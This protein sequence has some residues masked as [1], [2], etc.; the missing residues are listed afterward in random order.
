MMNRKRALF[1]VLLGLLLVASA[2]ASPVAPGD[3]PEVQTTEVSE[4]RPTETAEVR[5][6]E[7]A[8]LQPTDT[9]DVQPTATPDVQP[10]EAS[11][12]RPA[13][14]PDV[15]AT[16]AAATE[17]AAVRPIEE[18]LVSGP[19]FTDIGPTI[20]TVLAE[21]SIPMAC[22]AVYG[23]TQEYGQIATDTDM[24]GGGH[25]DHHPLLTGLEPDTVYYVRLQGVGPDGTLYQSEEYTFR[26]TEAETSETGL[27]LAL[28]ENGARLV[29]SSSNYGGGA[30][31]SSFGA[32]NATDGNVATQWSSDGDGDEAW[33]EIELAEQT[34]VT[35][36]GFW[37]RT[38]GSSAQIERF[39]VTTDKGETHGPFE[40]AD[41]AGTHY[42]DTDFVARRL[43]FDVLSSSGGNTGAVEIEVY[44]QQP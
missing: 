31:D 13:E 30:D 36:L 19:E 29:G 26:T 24:A 2:C 21:T 38:M 18:I 7:T 9:P 28:P 27:N 35:R 1:A 40:L 20:A 10:T 3:T 15:P 4:V 5:P 22:A 39:E 14:T 34:R 33:I 23:P 37:T 16:V 32:L 12:V 8:D 42:F 17:A 11:E 6:T 25:Q 41:A 44:G 43:R